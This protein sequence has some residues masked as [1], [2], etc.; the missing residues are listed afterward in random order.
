MKHT[1]FPK[2]QLKKNTVA[3]LSQDE[4][5]TVVGGEVITVN[6]TCGNQCLTASPACVAAQPGY[7]TPTLPIS[8]EHCLSFDGGGGGLTCDPGGQNCGSDLNPSCQGPC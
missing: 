1:N 7:P 3:K 8:I 6:L 2:L 4:M 5:M